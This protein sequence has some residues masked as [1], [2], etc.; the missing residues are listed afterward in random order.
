LLLGQVDELICISGKRVVTAGADG[1]FIF[2]DPRSP[3]PVFKFTPDD[4]R[5]D[6]G[7]ITSLAV[8]PASTL[9]VV[10]GASGGIRVISL[11]KGEIVGALGGHKEGESVE[12]IAFVGFAGAA[13]IVVTGGTDGKAHVWDLTTMRLRTTLEHGV[14]SSFAHCQAMTDSLC[15]LQDP[16]TVLLPLPSP[17]THLLVSGSAD[18]VL[19]TWD[20]R[21]GTLLR[22][23]KGHRGPVLGAALAP[24]GDS[25]V[26]A[27]DDG[28]CLVF[29]TE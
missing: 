15:Y 14:S 23:H 17:K 7:G 21:T 5:F 24:S 6:I 22:E 26:S 13:E 20:T 4:A 25:V 12:S 8:N 2:F 10:G 11:S 3:D 27:G 19:R 18:S 28:V 9:A 1:T 29:Q 16:V